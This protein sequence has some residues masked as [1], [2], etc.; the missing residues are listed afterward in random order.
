MTTGDKTIGDKDSDWQ[1]RVNTDKG[2]TVEDK[3]LTCSHEI[4]HVLQSLLSQ[5]L[6]VHKLIWEDQRPLPHL[7]RHGYNR[8]SVSRATSHLMTVSSLWHY[9]NNI[10]TVDI[11]RWQDSS[12]LL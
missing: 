5:Y 6:R 10:I 4:D 7:C 3:G 8:Y 11:I 9:T 1:E 2:L 12:E